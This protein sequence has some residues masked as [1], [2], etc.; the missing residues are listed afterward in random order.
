MSMSWV[1]SAVQLAAAA[2]F[3]SILTQLVS[4]SGARRKL[5]ADVRTEL[6][7]VEALRWA[8]QSEDEA[9]AEARG[10]NLEAGLRRFHVA[11]MMAHLPREIVEMYD[12][13]AQAAYKSTRDSLAD[14]G[15]SGLPGPVAGC[16]D[17]AFELLCDLLWRPWLSQLGYPKNFAYRGPY[18]RR[19]RDLRALVLRNMDLPTGQNLRWVY[20][21]P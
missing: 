3:G 14:K 4:G 2:G 16:V 7:T 19:M 6:S 10:I 11:A 9:A 18:R 20:P 5:R 21:N 15:Y 1:T 13:L 8:K 12:H 17:E